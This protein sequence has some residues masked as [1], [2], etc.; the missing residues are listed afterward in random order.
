MSA[1]IIFLCTVLTD[2]QHGNVWCS[3][4]VHP[5]VEIKFGNVSLLFLLLSRFVSSFHYF[6]S[7]HKIILYPST[8]VKFSGILKIDLD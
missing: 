6:V 5:F 7:K 1:V 3:S 2:S 4:G 8:T